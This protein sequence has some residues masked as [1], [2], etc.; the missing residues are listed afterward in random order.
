MLIKPIWYFE[1]N[2]LNNYIYKIKFI[3]IKIYENLPLIFGNYK[4]F[5]IFYND[6]KKNNFNLENIKAFYYFE[7]G[8][9][10]IVLKNKMTIKLPV[11]YYTDLLPEINLMLNNSNFLKYKVFDF[12]LKNRLILK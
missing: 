5:N 6:L 11:N 1:V 3:N 7:I 12:R 9:W 8:R 2:Y 10:D 4:N